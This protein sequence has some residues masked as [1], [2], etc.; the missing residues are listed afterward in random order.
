MAL[1][2]AVMAFLLAVELTVPVFTLNTIGLV[3]FSVGGK[4]AASTLVASWLC[5][6]GRLV[7]LVVCA[8]TS[9]TTAVRPTTMTSHRMSPLMGWCATQRAMRC[10]SEAMVRQA[11]AAERRGSGSWA[12]HRYYAS[13][14]R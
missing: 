6:P 10:R 7:S 12:E 3:P 9:D 4:S 5:V 8:P 2:D 13:L 11:G 14:T 1:T